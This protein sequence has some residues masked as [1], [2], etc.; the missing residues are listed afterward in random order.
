MNDILELNLSVREGG[1]KCQKESDTEKCVCVL[2]WK[3]KERKS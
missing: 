1:G 3:T 2:R